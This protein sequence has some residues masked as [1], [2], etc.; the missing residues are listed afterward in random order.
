MQ[1]LRRNFLNGSMLRLN[2]LSKV[3]K[4]LN[5]AKPLSPHLPFGGL[6]VNLVD[7]RSQLPLAFDISLQYRKKCYHNSV[8][9]IHSQIFFLTEIRRQQGEEQ[10]SII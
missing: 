10:I 6:C 5:E 1:S 3:N 8:K 9:C 2:L 4:I 7:D